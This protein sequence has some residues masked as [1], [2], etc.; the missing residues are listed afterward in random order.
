MPDVEAY[1]ASTV[2]WDRLHSYARRVATET[3]VPLRQPITYEESDTH[4]QVEAVGPHWLLHTREHHLQEPFESGADTE[5]V[6]YYVV[7]LPDGSLKTVEVVVEEHLVID[8]RHARTRHTYTR[9]HRVDNVGDREIAWLD[10]EKPYYE[11]EPNTESWKRS[12]GNLYGMPGKPLVRAKGE[13]TL[14]ALEEL[15]RGTPRQELTTPD[16][17]H[18]P[19]NIPPPLVPSPPTR[20]TSASR[21]G[22]RRRETRNA[23]STAGKRTIIAAVVWLILCFVI[24]ANNTM[25]GQGAPHSFAPGSYSVVTW[26]LILMV[27]AGLGIDLG[28]GTGSSG[29]FMIGAVIGF[30]LNMYATFSKP[31]VGYHPLDI[32]MFWLTGLFGVICYLLS[33]LVRRSRST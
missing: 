13:G 31:Y 20:P 2:D 27:A 23:F 3:A 12:W 33:A 10:I 19:D 4:Q 17:F 30:A 8:R 21:T 15:L 11:H 32:S 6:H 22:Q 16:Y 14:R 1:E 9:S 25:W 24:L 5:H 28:I 7:L 18:A 29:A 26:T